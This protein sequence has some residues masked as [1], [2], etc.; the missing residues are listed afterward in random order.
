M[1]ITKLTS[2]MGPTFVGTMLSTWA[3]VALYVAL[4]KPGPVFGFPELTWLLAFAIATPIAVALS[5]TMLVVDVFLL[6]FKLRTLPTG[7][8]GWLMALLSPIPVIATYL[9][10]RPSISFGVSGLLLAIFGPMLGSALM[11][12]LVVGKRI[13]NA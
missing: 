10:L 12:R 1:K 6:K 11:V 13:D 3:S 9:A 5:T 2:W 8:A 7:G 4:G